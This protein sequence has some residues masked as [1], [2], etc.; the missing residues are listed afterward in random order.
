MNTF[1]NDNYILNILNI[2]NIYIKL[3]LWYITKK[4]YIYI[5]YNVK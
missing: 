5:Y 1:I 3:I 2:L 4:I